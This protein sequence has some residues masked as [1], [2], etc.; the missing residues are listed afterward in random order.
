MV[1][2][3]TYN[4]E[5]LQAKIN[6]HFQHFSGNIRTWINSIYTILALLFFIIIVLNYLLDHEPGPLR[7]YSFKRPDV[8]AREHQ[9]R[10]LAAN[11]LEQRTDRLLQ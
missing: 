6:E 11:P 1:L 4:F 10:P 2:L 8:A 5:L 7:C 3:I 9:P